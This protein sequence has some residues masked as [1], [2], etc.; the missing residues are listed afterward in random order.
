[1]S[2]INVI[3]PAFNE[4]D[5]IEYVIGD[6]PNIVDDIIVVSNNSSDATEEN[7]KQAGATVLNEDKKGYGYA[8]L[9][10]LIQILFR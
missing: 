5:S 10:R 9:K 6:I 1:M 4:A 8:C 2:I 3:I 7:A